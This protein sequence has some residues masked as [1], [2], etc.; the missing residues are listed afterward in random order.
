MG[1]LE[2]HLGAF[3]G[4]RGDLE[5]S[6]GALVFESP[7]AAPRE[8]KEQKYAIRSSCMLILVAPL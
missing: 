3:L 7:K 2:V 6:L 4:P 1:A 8:G 5:R